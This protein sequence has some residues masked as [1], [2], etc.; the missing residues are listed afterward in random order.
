MDLPKE[1]PASDEFATEPALDNILDPR[2]AALVLL[3]CGDPRSG[4]RLSLFPELLWHLEDLARDEVVVGPE[5]ISPQ[6]CFG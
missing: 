5:T 6:D 3:H 1:S 2:F 4:V